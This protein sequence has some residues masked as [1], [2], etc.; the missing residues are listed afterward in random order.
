MPASTV[1]FIVSE[2]GV[3][4][5]LRS[6]ITLHNLDE[7]LRGLDISESHV[8]EILMKLSANN[9]F[10][11]ANHE[12]RS[13]YKRKRFYHDSLGYVKPEQIKLGEK[14]HEHFH[15]VPIGKSIKALWFD[16]DLVSHLSDGF[17]NITDSAVLSDF[18]DGSVFR[19]NQFFLDHPSAIKIILNHLYT[20]FTTIR[21][22]A[23]SE[24]LKFL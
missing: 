10:S 23:V 17:N 1:Q 15:Y 14:K 24:L 18:T 2:L 22:A 5:K 11:E 13:N 7:I 6:E 21:H 16:K 12:L 4:D 20:T 3:I 8:N 19:K 9:P